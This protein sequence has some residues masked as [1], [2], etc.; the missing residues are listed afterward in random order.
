[1]VILYPRYLI[2]KK[3]ISHN[4]SLG[5]FTVLGTSGNPSAVRLFPTESCS[6]PSTGRCYHIMA[7]KMSVGLRDKES[8]K[9]V[10]LTQLRRN[11]RSRMD[12]RSG[13]KRPRPGDYDINPAPDSNSLLKVAILM[14]T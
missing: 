8:K 4:A 6:C 5:V 12:K 7:V 13:R 1:M 10:N 2:D 11:T 14:H 9:S 3:L